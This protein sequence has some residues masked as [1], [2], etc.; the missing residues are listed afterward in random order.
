MEIAISI[1]VW[2]FYT[3]LGLIGLIV[4]LAV[5]PIRLKLSCQIDNRVEDARVALGLLWGGLGVYIRLR[6]P[7]SDADL[8]AW[9]GPSI[10]GLKWAVYPLGPVPPEK[11]ATVEEPSDE[12]VSPEVEPPS[13][14]ESQQTADVSDDIEKKPVVS[15]ED[16]PGLVQRVSEKIDWLTDMRRIATGGLSRLWG[17]I[18]VTEIGFRGSLGLGDPAKTGQIA[19]LSQITRR[20][21]SPIRFEV[22]PTFQRTGIDGMIWIGL[23]VRPWCV[24]RTGLF[25]GWSLVRPRIASFVRRYI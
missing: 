5:S 16:Q 22:T 10:M 1:V 11:K 4:V 18:G 20:L 13:E 25:V 23:M 14:T 7:T 21:G 17:L 9:V 3:L 24:W 6:R 15:P 12:D 8:H 19:G 2:V